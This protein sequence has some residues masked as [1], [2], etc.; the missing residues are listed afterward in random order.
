MKKR[1]IVIAAFL[2]CATLIAGIGYAET[3]ET[4]HINGKATTTATDI[5]VYFTAAEITSDSSGGGSTAG[6]LGADGA[7]VKSLTLTARGLKKANET[8]VATYTITN[9]SDYPVKLQAPEITVDDSENFSVSTS[10]QGDA[11]EVG[12][13]APAEY[14]TFRTL[15]A[16]TNNTYTFTVTV[17]LKNTPSSIQGLST[18]FLIKIKADGQ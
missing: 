4:L 16:G 1:R 11:K 17:T 5:A 2:I 8:V 9:S 14:E 13:G 15:G 6:V 7:G 3:F 12:E 10:F 18:D